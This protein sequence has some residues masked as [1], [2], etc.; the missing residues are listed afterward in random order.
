MT[1]KIVSWGEAIENSYQRYL[2]YGHEPKWDGYKMYPS[3]YYKQLEADNMLAPDVWREMMPHARLAIIQEQQYSLTLLN[4][5]RN[6]DELQRKSLERSVQRE[7]EEYRS[8]AK[9]DLVELRAKQYI[10]LSLFKEA[11]SKKVKHLYEPDA[12]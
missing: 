12:N 4:M 6:M 8:G 7:I 1:T 5:K 2:N 11:K 3:A 10:I 9:D